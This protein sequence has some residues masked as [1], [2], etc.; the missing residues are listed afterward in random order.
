[1][2]NGGKCLFFASL[3]IFG[4]VASAV[5]GP[6][7]VPFMEGVYNGHEYASFVDTGLTW[8]QANAK[9]DAMGAGWRLATITS[10]GE[11]DFVASLLYDPSVSTQYIYEAL[12]GGY[13]PLSETNPAANWTWVTGET[14]SYTNWYA[15]EPNDWFGPGSEQYLAMFWNGAWNDT[16]CPDVNLGG[17]VAERAVPEPS[18]MLLLGSGLAGLI[19]CGRERFRK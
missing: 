2:K 5:A 19:A 7:A 14:F 16:G 13:Q 8:D 18:T 6:I 4:S 15:G 10:E 17:Y 3:M 1:M 12:L 9:V 11:K